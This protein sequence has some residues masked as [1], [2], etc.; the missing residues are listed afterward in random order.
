[1]ELMAC[2]V[3]LSHLKKQTPVILYSD[4]KYVVDGI[5]KGWAKNWKSNGWVKSDKKPALNPDLWEK[6]IE[7][8]EKHDVTFEWVKGHAGIEEN[9]RCD[10]LATEAALRNSLLI[11]EYYEMDE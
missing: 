1:M 5:T 11:D 10:E 2:I 9:E 4:S 8:Y 6:L 3:A 7:L